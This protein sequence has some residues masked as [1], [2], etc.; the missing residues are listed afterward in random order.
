[1]INLDLNLLR[2]FDAL[3]DHRSV[4]RAAAHLGVS[5]SAV[6][7]ALARLRK[8][9]NDPLFL[10]GP[11]ELQPTTRATEMAGGVRR[12]LVQLQGALAGAA[13]EPARADRH[14]TIAA[15]S[16]FCTQLIP[17]LVERIRREAPG[18]SLRIVPASEMLIPLLDR[19]TIDLALG[20]SLEVPVRIVC[21]LLYQ[22]KMVW[23]ASHHNP[24]AQQPIPVDQ[25]DLEKQIVVAPAQPFGS[26]MEENRLHPF[27]GAERLDWDM[28]PGVRRHVTVY[29][30]QTAVALVAL[31][32]LIAR[33]PERIAALAMAQ[34]GIARLGWLEDGSSYKM[35]MIWHARQRSDPGLTW[36]RGQVRNACS[37]RRYPA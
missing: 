18:I 30:A 23:I 11:A 10:R 5:Q 37:E 4:T 21:E 13:F 20:A 27:T 17:A 29:D 26:V 1:M 34:G 36:L 16:Y 25:L 9:L 28:A 8:V 35:I 19:G 6:S 12:G 14:F 2:T 33:V 24:L 15:S 22:E 32:D 7:H 3:M 31:T